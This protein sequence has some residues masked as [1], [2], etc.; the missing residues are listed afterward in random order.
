MRNTNRKNV[1]TRESK[2]LRKVRRISRGDEMLLGWGSVAL[3]IF[4][5]HGYAREDMSRTIRG[6]S[7]HSENATVTG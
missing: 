2:S 3:G 6:L 7:C 1:T 4:I 5:S